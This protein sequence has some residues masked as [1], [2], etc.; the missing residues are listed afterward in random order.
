MMETFQ[1]RAI[2]GRGDAESIAIHVLNFIVA[3]VDRIVKFLNVT[4]LQ[5]KTIRHRQTIALSAGR[6]RVCGEGQ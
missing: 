3:D 2:A 4:G 6:A 5:P 1:G